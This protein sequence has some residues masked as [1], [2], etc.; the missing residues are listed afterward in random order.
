M[1]KQALVT[2][3][4]KKGNSC[5]VDNYR[6]ISLTCVL[7]KTFETVI[8]NRILEFLNETNYL[9]DAQHGFLKGKST[10]TNMLESLN[11]WTV[12]IN[13]GNFT[14]VAY[15]DFS[16]AFDSVCHNKLLYKLSCAGIDGN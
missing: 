14:R 5:L 1:W 13:N 6:P 4:F 12:N 10:C 3:I 16:K 7:C 9:S 11:D 15:V 8:K 2:P